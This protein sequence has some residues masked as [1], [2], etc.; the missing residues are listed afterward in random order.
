MHFEICR[1]TKK[2]TMFNFCFNYYDHHYN[3]NH[4]KTMIKHPSIKKKVYLLHVC[5]WFDLPETFG[6]ALNLAWNPLNT[7]SLSELK[8]MCMEPLSAWMTG[9]FMI[10]QN[11]PREGKLTVG[12]FLSIT[13]SY[14]QS[15]WNCRWKKVKSSW[16]CMPR[17]TVITQTQRCPF[18]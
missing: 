4:K 3:Y 16:T 5:Y 2:I 11:L 12:P 14:P 7:L 13:K 18:P 1:G 8:V 15:E 10:P 9:G 17:G 6:T